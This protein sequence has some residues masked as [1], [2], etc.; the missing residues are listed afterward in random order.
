MGFNEAD[1]TLGEVF[2]VISK[3][4]MVVLLISD[5]A[6]VGVRAA[7][8]AAAAAARRC[9]V[10][11]ALGLAL[12]PRP[13]LDPAL[14]RR[15]R[16]APAPPLQPSDEPAVTLPLLPVVACPTHPPSAVAPPP[17]PLSVVAPHPPAG[18]ALPPHPGGY[19]ARLHPGPVPR[20][21]AGRDAG[22]PH[23]R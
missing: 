8:A 2:D 12:A 15:S 7:R 4:D 9:D 13:A 10:E 22:G 5:A 21:P 11:A 3:S 17:D 23:R 16:A 14:R 19:E 20:L 1:G 18:Q 6:Q